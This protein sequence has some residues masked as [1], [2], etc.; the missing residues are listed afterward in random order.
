MFRG[1]FGLFVSKVETSNPDALLE[2]C[3]NQIEK[4]RR[5]AEQQIVEIQTNAE[6]IKIE[7]R[8]SEKKLAL[9]KDRVQAAQRS[10]D[11]EVLIE[12]LMLEEEAQNTYDNQKQ[13]YDIAMADVTKVR[14]DY[15]VFESEMNAKMTELKT[16]RSQAKMADLKENINSVNAKYASKSNRVANVNANMDRARDIVNQKT[17][18]ANAVESLNEDNIDMKIKRL[19]MNSSRDRAKARAEAMMAGGEGFEVKEKI[20]AKAKAES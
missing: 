6:L 10:G 20:E 18:R 9:A 3:K 2:D 16:L 14:E 5:E 12:T 13:T 15:R 19:D 1:F 4:A 17:A 7:L 8:S 11:K